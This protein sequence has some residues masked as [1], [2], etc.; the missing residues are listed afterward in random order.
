MPEKAAQ[1]AHLD[2]LRGPVLKPFLGPRSSSF[3]HLKP[4]RIVLGRTARQ[5][6]EILFTWAGYCS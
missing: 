4:C 5:P 6:Y 1:N 3:E 2:E